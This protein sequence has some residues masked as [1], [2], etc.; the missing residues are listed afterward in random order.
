[1]HVFLSCSSFFF[2]FCVFRK[3][4]A[5]GERDDPYERQQTVKEGKRSGEI[6]VTLES[7]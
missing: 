2:D 5:E 4:E 1:M 7:D 3:R 6:Y